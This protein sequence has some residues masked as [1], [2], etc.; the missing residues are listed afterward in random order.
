MNGWLAFRAHRAKVHL[1]KRYPI[2]YGT[3]G[4]YCKGASNPTINVDVFG[5]ILLV[6]RQFSSVTI[7]FFQTLMPIGS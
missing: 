2:A 7:V 6:Q 4:Y 3:T 1:M 5:S